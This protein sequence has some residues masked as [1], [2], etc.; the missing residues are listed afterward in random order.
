MNEI[1]LLISLAEKNSEHI[2]ILNHE[3][4]EIC[5]RLVLI[6]HQLGWID[7]FIKAMLIIVIGLLAERLFVAYNN[8]KN[9]K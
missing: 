9:W 2:E 7:W 8:R 5:T 6:E 3:F 4:G 1:Q